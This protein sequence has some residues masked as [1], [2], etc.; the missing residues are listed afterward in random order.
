VRSDKGAGIMPTEKKKTKAQKPSKTKKTRGEEGKTKKVAQSGS[1]KNVGDQKSFPIVG[2]G[3]SAGGLEALESLFENLPVKSGLAFVV[4]THT[5]PKRA[6]L[7]PSIIK[8]KTRVSVKLVEEAMAV[9]PDT[10]YLPPSDQDLFIDK[11]TFHLK[12]RPEPDRMHLPVDLF[13]RNLA[14]EWGERAAC[15]I[16]SGTGSDGT[17]GLRAIKEKSGLAV[18]QDPKSA[19]HTGMPS[20]AIDTGLVDFVLTPEKIPERLIEYFKHPVAIKRVSD[21]EPEKETD[22]IKGILNFLAKQTRHDFSLYKSST[23]KRRIARRIAVTR[24]QNENEYLRILFKDNQEVQALFQDLLIGVTSFFRDPEAFA[25]LKERILADLFAAKKKNQTLRV[26][27]PGCATGEDAYSVAMLLNEYM[28]ENDISCEIQIFGTDIDQNGIEKAR[29]GIYLENISADVSAQRLKQFFTKE[30]S[31]YR[32]KHDIRET[33]IFAE[34]NLLRDPPFSELDLLVCRNLLIYLKTEA[35]DKLIPLFHFTLRKDGILFLGNSETI[36]RFPE[37]FEQ[38]SK[39]YSIYRKRE[40]AVAPVVRFPTG[41]TDS[42]SLGDESKHRRDEL[43]VAEIGLEKAVEN[44]LVQEFTPVCVLINNAGEIIYTHGRTGK[45][46]EVA[47]GRPNWNLAVMARE[48]LRFPL[49]A[50]LR[51]ARESNEPIAVKGLKVKTNSEYQWIN[52]TVKRF[53]QPP[54]KDTVMVIFNELPA[55]EEKTGEPEQNK[56]TERQDDRNEELEQELL[57]VRQESRSVR[58]ELETSN[59]EL[60]SANE[61]MQSSNEELQSTNEELESSR[62]ELQSLNEELNTVNDELKNKIQ[63][64]HDS[65]QA[66]T[67]ALNSTGIAIVFLD[68]KLCITRF[69]QTAAKLINLIDA[70]VGRPLEHISVNLDHEGICEKAEQV[71]KTLTP[72]EEEVKTTD[73]IWY[74][75]NITVHREKDHV[76]EG[77]VMTFVDI[78]PQKKAQRE[79]E[80]VKTCEIMSAKWLAENIVDTVREALLVLDEKMRV[81][82]AN[83]RF[84]E[85]FGSDLK[86][87]EGKNLFELQ[88]GQWDLPELRKLLKQ[89]VERGKTFENYPVEY[90]F[91]N[92][93]FKKLLL[94][95]CH[96]KEDDGN[97]NKILLAIKDVTE[98]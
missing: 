58:E 67:D 12:N 15:V 95:G 87:I 23:L 66:V 65:Y 20:S 93:G 75:L 9:Q 37:L 94:N 30:D 64:L 27:V 32:I 73:G 97:K 17:L 70:D 21:K 8:R 47:P 42:V 44:I 38:R 98:P 35:Q 90:K 39:S 69:T 89:T 4:I 77:V 53:S 49:L 80:Q 76:I 6:S 43:A 63:E 7:L 2:I 71:L 92:V 41:K 5:D 48:G 54:L 45:Y 79:I 55:P 16:L 56:T 78:D 14:E 28:E 11:I 74:R 1:Q 61:E 33:V 19:K 18:V 13:L 81:I 85:C 96:L 52:L 46:L 59:E 40:S 68:K 36:G 22:H 25:Y 72:I 34:Q 88:N 82:T 26:W 31:R 83:R 57:R 84:Y 91:A 62:E 3:A 86:Q 50:A 51:K 10:V 60:R 29:S 24:S